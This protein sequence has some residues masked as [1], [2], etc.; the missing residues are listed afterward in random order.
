M[1]LHK[2]CGK[3]CV[4]IPWS[5][6]SVIFL[7]WR[8]SYGL[9]LWPFKNGS[10]G[11]KSHLLSKGNIHYV[12]VYPLQLL[13]TLCRNKENRVE[14]RERQCMR[15]RKHNSRALLNKKSVAINSKPSSWPQLCFRFRR[16]GFSFSSFLMVIALQ[17]HTLNPH[18]VFYFIL[19]FVPSAQICLVLNMGCLCNDCLFVYM[20]VHCWVLQWIKMHQ[21]PEQYTLIQN[22]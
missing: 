22:K 11:R 7:V 2:G 4:K 5:W 16:P 9:W 20:G 8:C 13:S 18:R 21:C 17:N 10:D 14:V 19:S 12:R 1:G 3:S 15:E 6:S